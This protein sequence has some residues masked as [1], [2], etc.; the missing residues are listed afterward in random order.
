MLHILF[1]VSHMLANK[2]KI[3]AL[4]ELI[5]QQESGYRQQ[6]GAQSG[7]TFRMLEGDMCSQKTKRF[8]RMRDLLR[9]GR[10]RRR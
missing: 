8:N 4:M 1:G 2:T 9:R 10:L 7:S 5:L 6:T 3:L